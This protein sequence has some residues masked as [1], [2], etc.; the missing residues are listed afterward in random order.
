MLDVS[1][2][3]LGKFQVDLQPTRISDVVEAAL[4]TARPLRRGRTACS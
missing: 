3:V 4:T 1:R 2:M